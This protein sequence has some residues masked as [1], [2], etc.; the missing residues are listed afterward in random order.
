MKGEA[1][2]PAGKSKSSSDVADLGFLVV[3]SLLRHEDG[4][5]WPKGRRCCITEPVRNHLHCGRQQQHCVNTNLL[6]TEP[7]RHS[8]DF[9]CESHVP[10]LLSLYFP[11]RE[12]DLFFLVSVD[13]NN[14]SQGWKFFFGSFSLQSFQRDFFRHLLSH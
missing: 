6:V 12:P 2:G 10:P 14:T 1:A 13:S 5:S 7:C 3:L 9:L 11:F 4:I 8:L